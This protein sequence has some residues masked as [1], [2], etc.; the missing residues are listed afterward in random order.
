MP[1]LASILEVVLTGTLTDQQIRQFDILS[2][3]QWLVAQSVCE[4][5]GRP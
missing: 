5:I 3:E 4:S 1:K 2:P